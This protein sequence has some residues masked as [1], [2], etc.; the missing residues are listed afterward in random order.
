MT[1]GRAKLIFYNFGKFQTARLA[2][3]LQQSLPNN[4][5]PKSSVTTF[6]NPSH[7]HIVVHCWAV[8][9]QKLRGSLTQAALGAFVDSCQLDQPLLALA[10]FS[11]FH[12]APTLPQVLLGGSRR[13]YSAAKADAIRGLVVAEGVPSN[14]NDLANS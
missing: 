13:Q 1:A 7:S 10:V 11:A 6:S 14:Q 4:L 8:S 2:Y 9:L 12:F 5:F 3:C